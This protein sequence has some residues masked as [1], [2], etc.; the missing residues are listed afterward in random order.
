M[1]LPKPIFNKTLENISWDKYCL[2]QRNEKKKCSNMLTFHE[3]KYINFVEENI[4]PPI[5]MGKNKI[6]QNPLP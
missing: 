3:K 4:K 6:K 2:G 1:R 5:L